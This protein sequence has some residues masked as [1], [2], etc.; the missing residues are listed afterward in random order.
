MTLRY[1][2]LDK[3]SIGDWRLILCARRSQ[4]FI[5]CACRSYLKK[6]ALPISFGRNGLDVV[7]EL[8]PVCAGRLFILVQQPAFAPY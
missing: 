7:P 2:D 1:Q 3:A 4:S 6:L 5:N 8:F